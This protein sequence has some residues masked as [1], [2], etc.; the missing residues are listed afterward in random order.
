M[1]QV[2][3]SPKKMRLVGSVCLSLVVLMT[4]T[5]VP[6]SEC[7]SKPRVQEESRSGESLTIA[8]PA[9]WQKIDAVAFSVFAPLGWKFKQLQGVDSY[10]GEFISDDVV[11]KFDF[12]QHS[13]PLKGAKEPRY[14]VVNKTIAGSRAKIVTPKTPG[15]G[16]TGIYFQKTFD[17]NKLTLYGQDL[18]A[19]Q[20]DLVLEIFETIRFGST[21][22]P[23]VA[24]PPA[25]NEP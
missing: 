11:L 19:R 20:Q 10:V 21:V 3:I 16:I 9:D 15:R 2:Q 25:K 7:S 8:T 6:A 23:V 4:T 12:G 14:V 22:P 24:P 17:S 18:T 5:F 13:N 1:T